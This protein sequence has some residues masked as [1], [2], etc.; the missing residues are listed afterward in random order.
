M[1]FM[2]LAVLGIIFP[3]ITG[4]AKE[5]S[6]LKCL[7][8]NE[9]PKWLVGMIQLPEFCPIKKRS[10]NVLGGANTHLPLCTSGQES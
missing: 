10:I 7:L 3:I 1:R 4:F 5:S 8:N 6:P 2:I 9:K